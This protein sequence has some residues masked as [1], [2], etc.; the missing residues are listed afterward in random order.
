MIGEIAAIEA[1]LLQL[2]ENMCRALEVL[3]GKAQ[4]VHDYWQRPEGGGSGRT[5]AMEGGHV[6]EKAGVNFSHVSGQQLPPAATT[7]RPELVGAPF[8]ALGLSLIVHPRNPYAPT[9]HF[10]LRFF[11]AQKADAAPL[12][13]FGG[14]C[15]LT[16]YYGFAEDCVH[17]H[18]TVKAAC[19]PFGADLYPRFKKWADDY[20]YLQHRQE[21]RGIGGVFFDDVQLEDFAQTFSFARSIGDHF[22]PAYIPIMQRRKEQAYTKKERAFQAYRRGRYVEFNLIYDRGTLFGLQWGGR[23][24]SILISL[25]PE[26]TWRYNWSPAMD[27]D[28]ARLYTEFLVPKEW[29]L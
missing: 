1:Y 17:W 12:W 4:F 3:D 27:T 29:V 19:D 5:H 10:N 23:V 28:E 6:I 20:F 9:V 26:V 21:H 22:L 2:Q 24:E 15:D 7:R 25:P 14:G 8:T 16:P 13:W 11:C 18:Q